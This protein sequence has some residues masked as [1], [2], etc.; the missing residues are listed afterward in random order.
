[1]LLRPNT[2]NRWLIRARDTINKSLE[3]AVATIVLGIFLHLVI[4]I[5]LLPIAYVVS[6]DEKL[7]DDWTHWRD[8]NLWLV[9]IGTV[10]VVWL[11]ALRRLF[12]EPRPPII[13]RPVIGPPP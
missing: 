2:D 5:A 6:G 4:I 1:M 12:T 3:V 10:A 7:V 11:L 8:G 13:R 9:G